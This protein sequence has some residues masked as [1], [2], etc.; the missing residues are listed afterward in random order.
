MMR[1]FRKP[2]DFVAGALIVEQ[3]PDFQLPEVAF[4]GR[5]NVGKSSLMNALVGQN[6]LARTSSKPGHTRQI[7]FFNLDDVLM[8]VD[9]PGY[10]YAKAP[11]TEIA[12]WQHLLFSYLRGRRQ[13]ARAFMLIDSRHGI[14]P[15]DK[16]MMDMLDDAA[17]SYQIVLTKC[18]KNKSKSELDAI[19]Q[20]C[21]GFLTNRPA[22]HPEVLV[23]AALAGEGVH[24][25]QHAVLEAA[26][27]SH[28]IE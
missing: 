15:P 2:I 3:L 25:L 14:K 6:K 9:V 16:D 8:L 19:K 20:D 21:E 18:D 5:S 26:Q 10:G 11:K 27:L 23:T 24:A 28:L 12:R 7:N 22:A 1:F 4:V 13:L 17:M